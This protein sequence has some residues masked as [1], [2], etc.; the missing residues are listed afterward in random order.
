ML[1][2]LGEVSAHLSARAVPHALIGAAALAVHG[3]SRSTFDVDLLTARR[4]VLH[5]SV[6]AALE[7]AGTTVDVRVGDPDDPLA[8]VVRLA[9]PGQRPVDLVVG[10]EAWQAEV[11]TRATP[12]VVGGVALPVVTPGDLVLLK[13]H[14]GG[15]QDAWDVTQ[16][17]AARGRAE[18]GAAVEANLPR[19]PAEARA[20]W[21]AIQR[22]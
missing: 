8:G 18:L 10:R 21:L 7:S 13:L 3:V 6:W 15:P 14:A 19:L 20:L 4:E 17:L 16:L 12:V 11:V 5:R 9:R 22:G 1:A 2:L